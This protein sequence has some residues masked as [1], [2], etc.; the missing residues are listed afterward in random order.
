MPTITLKNTSIELEVQSNNSEQVKEG[1]VPIEGTQWCA[2]Q[3]A[4]VYDYHIQYKEKN[5]NDE[6][7][8]LELKGGSKGVIKPN[9][10]HLNSGTIHTHTYVGNLFFE[11]YRGSELESVDDR[12]LIDEFNIKVHS[13]KVN[14]EQEYQFMLEEITATCADLLLRAS[15]SVHQFLI[16]DEDS[17]STSDYQRFKFVESLVLSESFDNALSQILYSPD[18]NW[19]SVKESTRISRVKMATPSIVK[20]IS[21]RGNRFALKEDD[22]LSKLGLD[23]VPTNVEDVRKVNSYDTPA[24]RFVKF[25]LQSVI[26]FCQ[27]ITGSDKNGLIQAEAMEIIKKFESTLQHQLFKE[28]SRVSTINLNNTKLQRKPGYRQV[29]LFWLQF[30]LASNLKWEGGDSVY[31]A[32]KKDVATLYEYWLFF[33]FLSIMESMF[34]ASTPKLEELIDVDSSGLTLKLKQ[35][36]ELKVEGEYR[37]NHREFNVLLRYNR[38]FS[39]TENYFGGGSW[40]LNLRPDYTLSFWPKD[41]SPEEAEKQELMVHLHFDAKYKVDSE[42]LKELRGELENHDEKKKQARSNTYK[43]GDL[44]KMH[45]YRDAIRRSYGSY[46]LFPGDSNEQPVK[47]YAQKEVL[48]SIGAFSVKPNIDDYGVEHLKE[49]L[50]DTIDNLSNRYSQRE[51][52]AYHKYSTLGEAPQKNKKSTYPLP[53]SYAPDDN[54]VNQRRGLLPGNT[55]VHVAYYKNQEHLEWIKS[56]RMYNFRMGGDNG[57]VE[58]NENSTKARFLLLYN[59]DNVL[60]T[61]LFE[62]SPGFKVK[63]KD[64]LRGYPSPNRDFYMIV[65]NVCKVSISEL[66]DKIWDVQ[67]LPEFRNQQ[68]TKL[69]GASFL[70]NLQQL[71]NI[72]TQTE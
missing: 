21:S 14:Y 69:E 5:H 39:Y 49:F 29:L 27:D 2:L 35:G 36:K 47:K 6:K 12:E 18:I 26:R 16:V 59:A 19:S 4:N 52:L 63:F 53:E 65:E 72:Q 9:G 10:I 42:F 43:N 54:D 66:R 8:W 38:S 68:G 11:I 45:A 48:P 70:I 55:Y 56:R 41:L 51:I 50:K 20:Q 22:P 60:T 15:S 23:S 24:N 1:L 34:N 44:L 31:A 67:Q 17:S 13:V 3:E 30:G 62:I 32:G 46:I 58:I 33:K 28:V 57:A 7:L 64:E 40:S 71:I 37:T 25:V 61:E